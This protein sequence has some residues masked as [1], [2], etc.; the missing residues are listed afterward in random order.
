MKPRNMKLYVT[1]TSPRTAQLTLAQA[2]SF[3]YTATD[4]H[5]HRSEPRR[6]PSPS[7][8]L[9]ELTT[10]RRNILWLV[11]KPP[12]K[13]VLGLTT[14]N[15]VPIVTFNPFFDAT[16][17]SGV[18]VHAGRIK[19]REWHLLVDVRKVTRPLWLAVQV[20]STWTCR[21]SRIHNPY[22]CMMYIVSPL[23][24]GG[25]ILWWPPTHSLLIMNR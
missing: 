24:R 10:N 21:L 11:E 2:T 9:A 16:L 23:A 19:F 4:S 15:S 18:K 22:A 20:R 7:R 3:D 8:I 25:G 13:T 17:R 5:I 6:I 12:K 14:A 1:V